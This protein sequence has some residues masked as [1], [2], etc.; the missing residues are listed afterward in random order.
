MG[1]DGKPAFDKR[2][3]KEQVLHP[4]AVELLLNPSTRKQKNK[5]ILQTGT[6]EAVA[7]M[8]E[9]AIKQ[10]LFNRGMVKTEI[11][12]KIKELALKKRAEEKARRRQ[13]QLRALSQGY[14]ITKLDFFKSEVLRKFALEAGSST[15]ID[16][17]SDHDS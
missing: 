10:G 3:T 13:A 12:F 14:D 2:A 1:P 5:E 8:S 7:K 11:E 6:Q 9:Y 15:D 4:Y 16:L 17:E